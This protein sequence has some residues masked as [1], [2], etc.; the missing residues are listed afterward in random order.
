MRWLPWENNNTKIQIRESYPI[1]LAHLIIIF[2]LSSWCLGGCFPCPFIASYYLST[3]HA[4][5]RVFCDYL[6]WICLSLPEC[7]LP[8][9]FLLKS[10]SSQSVSSISS[11]EIQLVWI[12]FSESPNFF[13]FFSLWYPF[14]VFVFSINWFGYFLCMI[15]I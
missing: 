11:M 10:F 15:I 4:K 6:S 13:S 9:C 5:S 12:C 3:V 14:F 7:I 2:M 8:L 1:L